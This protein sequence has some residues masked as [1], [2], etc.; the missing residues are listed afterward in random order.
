MSIPEQYKKV[1]IP[2]KLG[3]GT[4]FD[5]PIGPC[6]V[7]ACALSWGLFYPRVGIAEDIIEEAIRKSKF[8]GHIVDLTNDNDTEP[9]PIKRGNQAA[10]FLEQCGFEVIRAE[11]E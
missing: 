4:Y 5:D 1:T 8:N 7:G 2:E 9:N 3:M 11:F 10:S 6:A